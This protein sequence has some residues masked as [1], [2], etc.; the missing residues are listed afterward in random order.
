MMLFDLPTIT[1]RKKFFWICFAISI[2][3]V[4]AGALFVWLTQGKNFLS[5]EFWGMVFVA[6]CFD[7]AFTIGVLWPDK[8][9]YN[10]APRFSAGKLRWERM[11]MGD[12]TQGLRYVGFGPA[13]ILLSIF[14]VLLFVAEIYIESHRLLG[15]LLYVLSGLFFIVAMVL[16]LVTENQISRSSNNK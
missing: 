11:R 3:V 5:D 16:A 15:I 12:D 1:Q 2:I 4:V 10:F 14:A 7:I 6:G 8:F 9:N 13:L